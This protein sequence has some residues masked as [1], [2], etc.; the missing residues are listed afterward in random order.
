MTSVAKE[1]VFMIGLIQKLQPTRCNRLLTVR[2]VVT[3]EGDVVSLTV[4]ET[5]VFVEVALHEGSIAHVTGEV[6]RV[7]H[8]SDG[9]DGTTFTGF[10][11]TSAFLEEE[12][13]VVRCT[14][15]ISF[16][17]VT[18][19]SLKLFTALVTTEV[20][21]VHELSLDEEV[22]THN[23]GVTHGAHVRF[24]LDGSDFLF[25]AAPTVNVLG[26]RVNLITLS[27]KIGSATDANKMLGV[28]GHV[29]R[30][31]NFSSDNV[32]ADLTTFCVKFHKILLAVEVV[33]RTNEKAASRE[34]LRAVL[35][36][37]V[38]RVV[39]FAHGL[40]DLAIDGFGADHTVG[41]SWKISTSSCLWD[42]LWCVG[43]IV[44]AWAG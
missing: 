24:G 4:G 6:V 35:T 3:K 12:D 17:V 34:R 33:V 31:H 7:P 43:V 20:P 29:V 42:R 44:C 19:S 28:K 11:A 5:L 27:D 9:S 8:F 30:V 25:K 36:N 13:F 16:K 23:R 10:T 26:L 32:V 18:I 14:V 15:I 1:V 22:G 40:G 2:A 39:V 38:V 37:K 41:A 21:R